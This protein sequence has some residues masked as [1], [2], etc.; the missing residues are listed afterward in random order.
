MGEEIGGVP[1]AASVDPERSADRLAGAS[2]RGSPHP[3]DAAGASIGRY[4]ARQRQLREI[5]LDELVRLTKIPRR[6]IERLEAGAF[7][8]APDGFAR[9]FVRT[10]AEA[11]GL[12]PAEAVMRLMNEPEEDERGFSGAGPGRPPQLAILGLAATGALILVLLWRLVA[13][14]LAAAPPAP[15]AEL[16]VREDLVR[17][18]AV[19]EA[20]REDRRAAGEAAPEQLA[21]PPPQAERGDPPLAR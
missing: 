10:V 2:S 3:G 7:D 1:E 4:L 18:L 5:S 14:W 20:E 11:L 17:A 8:H 19:E 9:G 16:V 15:T 12:D 13:G 21:S 6:S